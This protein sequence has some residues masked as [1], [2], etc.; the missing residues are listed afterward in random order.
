MTTALVTHEA[1]RPSTE[2]LL[3]SSILGSRAPDDVPHAQ[4]GSVG[5]ANP[6]GALDFKVANWGL[7]NPGISRFTII[8]LSTNR[9][10]TPEYSPGFAGWK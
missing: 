5:H 1:P 4:H 3:L 7:M 6:E 2:P 8:E 9:H 10:E